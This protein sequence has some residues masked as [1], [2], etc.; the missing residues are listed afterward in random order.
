MLKLILNNNAGLEHYMF[1]L[2]PIIGAILWV[3]L[4]NIW[5]TVELPHAILD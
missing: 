1:E 3:I 5:T 4:W 2:A